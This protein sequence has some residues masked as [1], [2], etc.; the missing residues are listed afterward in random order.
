MKAI[1][2]H[3]IKKMD[4][5][6][7]VEIPYPSPAAG[8]VTVKLEASALNHRDLWIVKGLYARIKVPIVL[9]SDGCGK[10][11][12]I[13][14]GVGSDWRGQEV[15][16]NPAL[17]WGDDPAVQQESFQILGM[18]QF[19]TQAEFVVVPE[20]NL[21]LK[22]AH[23]SYE[24]AAALPL[25]GLT[26]YRALFVQGG[27]RGGENVLLTGIGG[28]VATMM[29]QMAISVGD[30]V[31]VT[32]GDEQKIQRA[33]ASGAAGGVNYHRAEWRKELESLLN[34]KQ[35]DLVVDSAGGDNF[36]DLLET[37]KP[38]GRIVILGATAGNPS[39]LNL[40]RLFWKQIRIQGTTMGNRQDFENMLNF[41]VDRQI[42]P[43]IDSVF[44]FHKYFE[45]FRRMEQAK[46]F[47]KIV[48]RHDFK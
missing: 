27:L 17:D 43:M 36:N 42:R 41:I 10:V 15:V 12:E 5:L 35:I 6:K 31:W 13:G 44:E 16:L 7:I 18:P 1:M 29:L 22:P 23:L 34:G 38:G 39:S 32:S 25:A 45:A 37:V 28:G 40:R 14:E 20:E 48:L 30:K 3:E 9:G 4:S 47:G 8:E 11:V 24:E 2:L 21:H 33:M 26:G 46:Q 19:G